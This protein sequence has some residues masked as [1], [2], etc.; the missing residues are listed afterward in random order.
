MFGFENTK[1]KINGCENPIWPNKQLELCSKHYQRYKRS[2]MAEDG[3]LLP[4]PIKNKVCETCGRAFLIKE[5]GHN[6]RWCPS[7]RASEYAKI[8]KENNVG[9]YRR[10]GKITNAVDLQKRRKHRI[11]A[12]YIKDVL[13]KIVR[14]CEKI[15]KHRELLDMRCNG[16]TY[17]EIADRFNCTRQNVQSLCKKYLLT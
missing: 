7:C 6:A 10:D 16:K 15:S 3:S 8:Q 17:K 5:K 1:C 13:K 11:K 12:A 9:I 14:E 4:L 2:R